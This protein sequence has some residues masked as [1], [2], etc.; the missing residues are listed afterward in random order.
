MRRLPAFLWCWFFCALA[1]ADTGW[2][3][4]IQAPWPMFQK[5]MYHTGQSSS[6]GLQIQKAQQ[7]FAVNLEVS[8]IAAPIVNAEGTIYIAGGNRCL[9]AVAPDGSADCFFDDIDGSV[10]A[11]P[12]LSSEG[13]LYIATT[14]GSL[15]AI[16]P[17][18]IQLWKLHF[19]EP[20]LS[21]PV[22]GPGRKLFFGSG[23]SKPKTNGSLHCVSAE[24]ELLWEYETGSVGYISP[25]VDQY[26]TII[27]ASLQGRVYAFDADGDLLWTYDAPQECVASPV[28]GHDDTIYITTPSALIAL[29][30]SGLPKRDP[31]VP[32]ITIFDEPTESGFASAPAVDGNGNLFIGGILGD[33]HSLDPQGIKRWS[34]MVKEMTIT[35]PI[36]VPI[37]AAPIIDRKGRIYVRS[38]NYLASLSGQNGNVYGI[39]K[40]N[41]HEREQTTEAES[42]PVFGLRRTLFIPS[43]DGKLY[44]VYPNQRLL[45]VSGI[46]SGDVI[47]GIRI[48]AHSLDETLEIYETRLSET[49]IYVLQDLYPGTYIITPVRNGLRFD[50]PARTVKLSFGDAGNINFTATLTGAEIVSAQAIPAKIPNNA[51]TS[52][53]YTAKVVHPLGAGHIASVTIDLLS[54]GGS[55]HQ[56]L[57]DDGTHGDAHAGDGIYSYETVI[58]PSASIQFTGLRLR[59]MDTESKVS[60]SVIAVEVYNEISGTT[61]GTQDYMLSYQPNIQCTS[62]FCGSGLFIQ[63]QQEG[64]ASQLLSGSRCSVLQEPL[65]VLQIFSP[66]NTGIIPDYEK[67]FLETVQKIRIYNAQTGTWRYRIVNQST[68]PTQYNITTTSA[69]TGIIFGT[70]TDAQTGLPVEQAMVTTSLGTSTRTQNGY[71]VLMSPAGVMTLYESDSAHA[72]SSRSVNLTAG[73]SVEANF[74]LLPKGSGTSGSCPVETAMGNDSVTLER[75]RSFRD[76]ILP[77]INYPNAIA[78]YY[79]FA[80]EITLLMA[81][82]SKLQADITEAVRSLIPV[83]DTMLA[84]GYCE[85]TSHQTSVILRVLEYLRMK[86]SPELIKEIDHI[87]HKL[88]SGGFHIVTVAPTPGAVKSK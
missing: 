21:S 51:Q 18:G 77:N 6:Y 22:M 19:E 16:S 46:V 42:S 17:E 29:D 40:L 67:P 66:S 80:P 36:P 30:Y 50:P 73:G 9:Y 20:L 48:Y 58:D 87:K 85:L 3:N 26:G 35:D 11:T 1:V 81:D 24:G 2:G 5:D 45:T 10:V 25:A 69:G 63:F 72:P 68:I 41:D 83:V 84:G 70:V 62:D 32:N 60:E 52:I 75:L 13:I 28:I 34:V 86:A 88:K 59:V 37:I 57:Y 4:V 56:P 47:E 78:T 39:M 8:G 54:I 23:T 61:E 12:V 15:Y 74:L 7:R 43:T 49:G 44:S 53:L 82:D 79:R 31:F 33:M 27:I 65:L 71:Y 76:R 14:A 55:L 64:G 38:G